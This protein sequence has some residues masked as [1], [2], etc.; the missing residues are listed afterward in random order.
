MIKSL[1]F[2]F[3]FILL[4][5][6]ERGTAQRLF[7][8]SKYDLKKMVTVPPVVSDSNSTGDYCICK[9]VN[10]SYRAENRIDAIFVSN[11]PAIPLSIRELVKDID[12]EI[13][14]ALWFFDSYKVIGQ[15]A[16]PAS[17][18]SLY[19][20]LLTRHDEIKRSTFLTASYI[21]RK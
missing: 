3:I 8:R 21:A 4:S 7:L 18:K 9:I 17:C 1:H 13:Q 15:Y 2:F 11:P 20:Y 12:K 6:A 19:Q 5:T 10:F 16:S 14:Q